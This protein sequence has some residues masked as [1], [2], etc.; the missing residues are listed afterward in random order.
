[1]TTIKKSKTGFLPETVQEIQQKK[2]RLFIFIVTVLH[3]VGIAGM[4]IPA[5]RP[6]F[7][8]LTPFNLLLSLGVLM[9]FHTDWN[10]SFLFFMLFAFT[11][12]FGSEVLGVHTGFP[13]GNYSYGP[14]LGPKLFE[15]PLMIGVNWLI[16][17]YLSGNLLH[18]RIKNDWLAAIGSACLMVG[19]DFLI[20]PVAVALDFWSWESGIIP[21]SNY[22]GWFG[23]AFI[24]QVIY[25]KMKFQ[26]ANSISL[27]LLM[28]III[29][30][31][32]LNIII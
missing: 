32:S 2:P 14:V 29:F 7:Q 4:S 26:K 9:L 10:K 11:I 23:T 21:L 3:I 28:N 5:V 1:L 17:V 6:I 12:G 27:F 13:F 31:A 16:L 22:F 25:R 18:E 20:E 30:F 15:V 8:I 19:I 24:I